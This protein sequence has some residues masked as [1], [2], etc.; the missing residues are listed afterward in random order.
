[1]R[2]FRVI[3][4]LAFILGPIFLIAYFNPLYVVYAAIFSWFISS[5][6]DATYHRCWAHKMY[7][8]KNR[9]TKWLMIF[10]GSYT[11]WGSI[12]EWALLHRVHHKWPDTDVDPHSVKLHG[13]FNV[14]TLNW[15]N[16]EHLKQRKYV[17]FVTDLLRD[18]DVVWQNKWHN[19]TV[20]F[21]PVLLGSI[22]FYYQSMEFFVYTY[23]VPQFFA[24]FA[25]GMLNVLGHTHPHW[26][27]VGFVTAGHGDHEK[28]HENQ[29]LAKYSKTDFT[30]YWTRLFG[31]NFKQDMV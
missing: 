30:Y 4:I 11:T 22:A 13:W 24:N 15:W 14:W 19:Y 16:V 21:W 6:A 27:W 3:Q 31:K 17:K 29:S 10:L 20:L 7:E 12:L 1:M 26:K 25:S 28:H 2:P 18:K 9:F 23:I 8:P 5:I